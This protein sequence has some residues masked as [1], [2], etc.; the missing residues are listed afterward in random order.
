[1]EEFGGCA[2]KAADVV[3]KEHKENS[4][5]ENK[6]NIIMKRLCKE[7]QRILGIDY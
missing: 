1:V 2:K 3:L 5:T 4:K 6:E 7:N